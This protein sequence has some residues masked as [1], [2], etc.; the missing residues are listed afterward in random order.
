MRFPA[1]P[2]AL[3]E[4]RAGVAADGARYDARHIGFD[5]LRSRAEPANMRLKRLAE[6]QCQNALA[7]LDY[8]LRHAWRG[9]SAVGGGLYIVYVERRFGARVQPELARRYPIL[10]VAEIDERAG[11]GAA[12][13]D[14]NHL[15][16]AELRMTNIV[17]GSHGSTSSSPTRRSSSNDPA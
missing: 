1:A 11:I 16:C 17:S 15:A 9:A 14:R 3:D 7:R 12:I 10:H 13:L 5:S 4:D 2:F 6:P 8:A